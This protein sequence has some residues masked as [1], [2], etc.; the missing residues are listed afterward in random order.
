ML[1][2]FFI[3]WTC[4][5]TEHRSERSFS[6]WFE[7]VPGLDKHGSGI[8]PC[9]GICPIIFA[10]RQSGETCVYGVERYAAIAVYSELPTYIVID[11]AA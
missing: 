7:D 9:F 8:I 2:A 4:S 11:K 10:L 3:D 6:T 5:W 1:H